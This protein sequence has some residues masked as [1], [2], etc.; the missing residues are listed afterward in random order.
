MMEKQ[1][2][3]QEKQARGDS[4]ALDDIVE[5]A[6]KRFAKPHAPQRR[7]NRGVETLSVTSDSEHCVR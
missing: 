3:M 6:A 7:F 2:R 1:N 4:G 5:S